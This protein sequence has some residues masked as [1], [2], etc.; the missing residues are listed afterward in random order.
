VTVGEADHALTK[1]GK[2]LDQPAGRVGEVPR[3]GLSG[4]G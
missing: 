1:K 2:A 4:I 3:V